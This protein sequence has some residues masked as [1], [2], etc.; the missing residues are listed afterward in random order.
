[1]TRH[2]ITVDPDF[3]DT[4]YRDARTHTRRD[5]PPAIS[6]TYWI[7]PTVRQANSRSR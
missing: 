6:I 1:M 5:C 7:G 3:A 4:L 2:R